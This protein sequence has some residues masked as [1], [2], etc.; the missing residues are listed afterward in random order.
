MYIY[1]LI[2][3]IYIYLFIKILS[4]NI[5]IINIIKY[6][7][8]FFILNKKQKKFEYICCYINYKSFIN[9]LFGIC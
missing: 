1:L 6:A 4:F 2:P 8:L 7:Y 3:I 9:T 5:L